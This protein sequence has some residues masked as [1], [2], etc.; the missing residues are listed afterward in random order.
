MNN[1]RNKQTMNCFMKYTI[2]KY[3]F[4]VI[5]I[6][7]K[8]DASFPQLSLEIVLGVTEK[9]L[10][11]CFLI[12]RWPG[13]RLVETARIDLI[14]VSSTNMYVNISKGVYIYSVQI[15]HS[16]SSESIPI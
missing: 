14:L 3:F 13:F 4:V 7:K 1:Q 6:K 5:Q 9:N 16:L 15:R 10:D 2:R 8:I 11:R 12:L